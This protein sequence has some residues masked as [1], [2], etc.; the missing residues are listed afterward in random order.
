MGYLIIL[1]LNRLTV[2][3][4]RWALQAPSKETARSVART[5]I[6]APTVPT[7]SQ[8]THSSYFLSASEP[9]HQT[10]RPV[11][12]PSDTKLRVV[13]WHS[14]QHSHS[15]HQPPA[16]HQPLL[17]ARQTHS[18]KF[19]AAGNRRSFVAHQLL[20]APHSSSQLLAAPHCSSLISSGDN[21][22]LCPQHRIEQVLTGVS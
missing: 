16:S 4:Y 13:T 17:S 6:S 20:T 22:G 19:K 1:L 5:P 18:S 14:R 3:S 8:V 21:P 10:I 11:L 7:L 15:Q 9:D 2:S 12:G